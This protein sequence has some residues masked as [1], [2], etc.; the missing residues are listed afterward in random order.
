MKGEDR[1]VWRGRRPARQVEPL[2]EG[3]GT[4]PYAGLTRA[5]SRLEAHSR[6]PEEDKSPRT[7]SE[8]P[9]ASQVEEGAARAGSVMVESERGGSVALNTDDRIG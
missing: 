9:A 2:Q 1:V 3:R 5:L 4:H 8:A 7:R 6:C